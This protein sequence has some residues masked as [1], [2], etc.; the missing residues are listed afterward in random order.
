MLI[1][2]PNIT[3]TFMRLIYETNLN[4]SADYNYC[5]APY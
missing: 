1:T 3:F 2:I 5:G 4:T